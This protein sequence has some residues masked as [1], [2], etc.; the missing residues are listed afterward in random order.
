MVLECRVSLGVS[1]SIVASARSALASL[2]G[3]EALQCAEALLDLSTFDTG[4]C[5]RI[6]S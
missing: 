5:S 2:P 4:P 1:L 6:S 3:L